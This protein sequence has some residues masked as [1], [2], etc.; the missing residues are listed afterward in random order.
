MKAITGE[1]GRFATRAPLRS[2]EIG[3]VAVGW[4]A[5][6]GLVEIPLRAYE[7]A[8]ELVDLGLPLLDIETAA[9]VALEQLR[10]LRSRAPRT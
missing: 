4:R 7:L 9:G 1:S 6:D 10:H 2:A 5:H 3:D 8:V